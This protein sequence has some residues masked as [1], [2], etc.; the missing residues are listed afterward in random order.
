MSNMGYFWSRETLF[1][2]LEGIFVRLL[3]NDV[4][5]PGCNQVKKFCMSLQHSL[6]RRRACLGLINSSPAGEAD[7]ETS[8]LS[9]RLYDATL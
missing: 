8:W 2:E 6:F 1:E 9:S 4:P 7:R 3:L 5:S